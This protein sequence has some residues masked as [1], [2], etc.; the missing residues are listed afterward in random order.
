MARRFCLPPNT[1]NP[2]VDSMLTAAK[3]RA[4]RVIKC[5]TLAFAKLE[6]CYRLY[7]KLYNCS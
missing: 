4:E 7:N 2:L 3:S 5:G 1:G 6:H